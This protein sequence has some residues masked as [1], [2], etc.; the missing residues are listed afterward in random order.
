MTRPDMTGSSAARRRRWDELILGVAGIVV[1]AAVLEVLPR[2]GVVD[3]RFF[4]PFT[5]MMGAF[6]E[7]VQQSAFWAA[8]GDTL[9]QWGT[10][11]A[12]A[13]GVGVVLGI[14]IGTAPGLRALTSSTVEF[15]RPIPSVAIIPIAVLFFGTGFQATVVLVIY[16]AFWQVFIQVLYGVQD[17]DPVALET[18]RV[19]RLGLF[20][21]IG[22]VVVPSV[23]PYV[24]TGF[25]LAATVAL[26]LTIT[27]EL[28]I[29]ASGLGRLVALSQQ[30]GAIA[31]TF[32]LV[33][34][35][36]LIGVIVNLGALQ[37]ERR[38]LFWHPS[39]RGEQGR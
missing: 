36:G 18:A 9:A 13:T 10:G 11:L 14:V 4:P 35:T 34:V 22:R 31:S 7:R 32:A 27:G 30:G 24:L 33:I 39:I 28:V 26:I 19:Y 8:V 5:E 6:V 17:I 20:S 3:A 37:V 38:L 15:L 16:A 2:L 1:L 21:R 12:I 25:R 23:L 29:G